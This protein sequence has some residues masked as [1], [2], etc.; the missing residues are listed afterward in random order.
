MC[1]PKQSPQTMLPFPILYS[2]KSRTQAPVNRVFLYYFLYVRKESCDA[3]N[4]L[5]CIII[6]PR[7]AAVTS[8]APAVLE[9]LTDDLGILRSIPVIFTLACFSS[10]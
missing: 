3:A 1:N 2:L 7:G 6:C 9:L 5:L 8:A 4:E 10:K